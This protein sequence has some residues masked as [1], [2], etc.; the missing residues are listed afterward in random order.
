MK[1]INKHIILDSATNGTGELH[2]EGDIVDKKWW[3]EDV[4]PKEVINALK[5]MGSVKSMDVYVNSYGGSCIAGNSIVSIID[6]YK[7]KNGCTVNVY[8]RGIAASM[9]SGIAMVG[10]KVSMAKNALF[11]LHKPLSC[12]CGNADDLEKMV[13]VL[14]KTETTL[15]S[16]YMRRFNGTEDELRQM[17]KDETWMNAEEAKNY[18][19]VDEITDEIEIAASANGIRV[20]GNNFDKRV[21][22]MIKEK[23]PNAKINKKEEKPLTYDEKL[24]EFG[25]AEDYFATLNLASDKVLEM[26]SMIKDATQPEPAKE[27]ISK[28]AVLKALDVEDIEADAVMSY[29]KAG[30]NP[31]D[32]KAIKDKAS[33][34]DKIVNEAREAARVNAVRALGSFYNEERTTKML[35]V[36]DYDDVVAQSEAWNKQ[37]Q[38]AL[39]AG[40][41]VSVV[42]KSYD[43]NHEQTGK[44]NDYKL[45][46]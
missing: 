41:R 46:E 22:D 16:N 33:R 6:E 1:I 19:F 25:I 5:D 10:D 31:P 20:N 17:L 40:K 29:A 8:I 7:R 30:M 28:D 35:S 23:Y 27:F 13:D 42:E 39:N 38:E 26:A 36:L 2:I 32:D 21:A 9:G 24:G 34:Y 45:F 3:D 12:A 15:I 18:G 4:T 43:N 44:N 11:M 14:N 37:A